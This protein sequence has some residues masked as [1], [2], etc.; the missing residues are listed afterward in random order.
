MILGLTEG[1]DTA[2]GDFFTKTKGFY[3]VVSKRNRIFVA[4]F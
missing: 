4:V 2:F 1:K 3:F